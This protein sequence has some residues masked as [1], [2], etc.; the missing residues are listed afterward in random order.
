MQRRKVLLIGW[1]SADWKVINS[2]VEEGK[3]PN[4]AKWIEGGA[5][6]ILTTLQLTLSPT[7][8]TSIV[9]GKRSYKYGIYGFSEHEGDL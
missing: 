3:I 8:G 9:T 7:L 2:L 1:E 5:S 4:L 6:G